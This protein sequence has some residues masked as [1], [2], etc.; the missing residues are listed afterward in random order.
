VDAQRRLCALGPEAF[1]QTLL[2]KPLADVDEW[3]TEMQLKS[4]RAGRVLLYTTGLGADEQRLTGVEMIGSVDAAL[5]EA[6]ARSGDRD[7]AVIPE[8]PYVI[9][10]V[11]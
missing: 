1:L 9:P 8:G 7:V 3:Q 4:L 11:G 10:V 6:V 5:A 2:A